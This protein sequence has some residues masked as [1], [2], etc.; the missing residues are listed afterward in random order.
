RLVNVSFTVALFV[1]GSIWKSSASNRM[2]PIKTSVVSASSG[3]VKGVS[4]APVANDEK[5][6]T[7]EHT[8]VFMP[9]FVINKIY[10]NRSADRINFSS[11][12]IPPI[13]INKKIIQIG[14]RKKPTPIFL[15]ERN[16]LA[17]LSAELAAVYN[18][19]PNNT[20]STTSNMINWICS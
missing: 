20:T 7:N 18:Q 15:A 4:A 19:K 13:A 5:V 6:Q 12:R 3:T 17:S 9:F 8:S 10:L 11:L 14:K 1:L 2:S 16:C